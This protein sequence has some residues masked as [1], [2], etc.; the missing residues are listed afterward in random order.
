MLSHTNAPYDLYIVTA[1]LERPGDG[2][3]LLSDLRSRPRTRNC[4]VLVVVEDGDR[5]SAAMALD[6]GAN[7]IVTAPFDADEMALRML[8]QTRRKAQSDQ[9]RRMVEDGLQLAVRD[10]LTGLHNRRYLS[11]YLAGHVQKPSI[12]RRGFGVMH[13]DVDRFKTVN[14][15][16]GHAAGDYVLRQ[17]ADI[18]KHNLRI[19]DLAVRM[20]GE[21]FLIVVNE[22]DLNHAAEIAERLRMRIN[23]TPFKLP[24][25]RGGLSISASIGLAM[26]E[27]PG[28]EIETLIDR[29]DAALY[30]AKNE[31]RNKVAVHQTA[32]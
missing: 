20:G 5:D 17:F 7:D 6:L 11:N 2:L 25:S 21:E 19:S 26:W 31:G 4:S 23:A 32:A 18:L 9:L 28:E 13:V 10:P 8:T 24:N 16:F 22:I 29:A 27:G 12:L 3:V 30:G 14:D 15:R 1:D